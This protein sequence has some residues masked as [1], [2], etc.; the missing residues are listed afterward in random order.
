MPRNKDFKRLVRARMGKTG[1]SY[2]AARARMAAPRSTPRTTAASSSTAALLES[3]PPTDYA[4]RA[5]TSDATLKARTGCTWDKWVYVLDRA[6]AER[7][8]H[9]DIVAIVHGKYKVPGWWAQAVTVGYERIK[10]LRARGQRTD[11]TY[12]ATKSRTFPVP[13]ATLF[14]AWADPARRRRWLDARVGR[15]RTSTA[16]KSMRLDGKDGSII[17][18][19]FFPKGPGKS[20]VALSQSKLP[21]QHAATAVKAYWT[22]RLAALGEVLSTA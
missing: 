2:T 6:G 3:E 19:G 5:G 13:V 8:A 7:M 10:G 4:A 14:D 15:V 22:E 11:G 18:V 17:A 20:M 16:P 9:R 1:E 21:D 12:E